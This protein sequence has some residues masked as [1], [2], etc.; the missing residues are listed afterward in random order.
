MSLNI[1][2]VGATGYVGEELAAIIESRED[3]S[4]T[5]V[6][7]FSHEGKEYKEVYSKTNSKLVLQSI[8]QI[9]DNLDY[10]FFATK[11][12][13]SMDYVPEI[14]K[15]GIKVIDL[16]ADFRLSNEKLWQETYDSKHRANDL[17]S[18]AIYG[19]PEHSEEKIK[20]ANLVAVPGC[21]PTASILGLLP[22][23]PYLQKKSKIILDAK[24]GIS[25]AGKSSVENGLE[26]DI[27]EN[28]KSYN[29]GFHRHQPEIKDFLKIE[30]NLDH[31]IIFIPHLLPLFRGEYVTLYCELT[32]NDLK[33]N[34]LY[35]GFYAEHNFVRVKATGEI[36]EI[37]DV[38]N[39]FYCDISVSYAFQSNT[40]VI[41]SAIDNL[42]KGAA[43]QAI[44]CLDIMSK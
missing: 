2:I 9:P 20:A 14:L 6:S 38:I 29:V 19:L 12:D 22:V 23:V 10:V 17:L 28:F 8:N 33:L 7:S 36:A 1:G 21:Y 39:T 32:Q 27:K 18:K 16:S 42:L 37:K 41:T 43:S 13:Y 34:D 30:F 25:G 5:F 31:E 44:Q 40:I 3:L 11:H 15:R 35:E 24:S 4:L 26:E